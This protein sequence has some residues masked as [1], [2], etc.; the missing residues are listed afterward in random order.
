M[1]IS[2]AVGERGVLGDYH[3]GLQGTRLQCVGIPLAVDRL[4]KGWRVTCLLLFLIWAQ[5]IST[6]APESLSIIAWRT[7]ALLIPSME[8]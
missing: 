8:L 4:P 3:R 5:F 2:T 6:M 1:E 7:L